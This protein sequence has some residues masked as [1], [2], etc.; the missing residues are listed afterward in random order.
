[1]ASVVD[2]GAAANEWIPIRHSVQSGLELA[3]QVTV[4]QPAQELPVGFA[5][6]W[7]AGPAPPAAFFE[8]FLTNTHAPQAAPTM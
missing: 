4:D 1:M 7:I 5:Q 8:Q 6:T 2:F 3:G